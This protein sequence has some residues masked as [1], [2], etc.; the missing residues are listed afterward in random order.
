MQFCEKAVYHTLAN[1]TR[2]CTPALNDLFYSFSVM[3][4]LLLYIDMFIQLLA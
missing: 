3:Y 2:S 4:D 1:L